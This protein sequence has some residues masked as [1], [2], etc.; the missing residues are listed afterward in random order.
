MKLNED[1]IEELKKLVEKWNDGSITL[2]EVGKVLLAVDGYLSDRRMY[3]N[4]AY[5]KRLKE[6]IDSKRSQNYEGTMYEHPLRLVVKDGIVSLKAGG[7]SGFSCTV[8]RGLWRKRRNNNTSKSFFEINCGNAD[9]VKVESHNANN[10]LDI[11]TIGYSEGFLMY[12]TVES[13][14]ASGRTIEIRDYSPLEPGMPIIEMERGSRGYIETAVMLID[15]EPDRVW[16]CRNK[17]EFGYEHVV[18]RTVWVTNKDLRSPLGTL[19]LNDLPHP[20]EAGWVRIL[21]KDGRFVVENEGMHNECFINPDYYD[22]DT[23][24]QALLE[25]A[26]EDLREEYRKNFQERQAKKEEERKE[27]SDAMGI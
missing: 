20:D 22:E 18:E 6:V 7:F 13:I 17:H 27:T 9:I 15:Q 3:E 16:K 26:D 23:L 5:M 2:E 25:V 1:Q 12:E 21:A 4:T 19:S 11:A 8:E 24:S 14:N 10:Y